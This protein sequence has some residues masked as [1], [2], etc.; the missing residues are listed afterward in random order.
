MSLRLRYVRWAVPWPA[1]ATCL[2]LAATGVLLTWWQEEAARFVVPLVALLVAA[3]AAYALDDTAAPVTRVTARG[4]RWAMAHRLACAALVG[5]AGVGLIAL[6]PGEL[7]GLE[8]WPVVISGLV[9]AATASA[10]WLVRRHHDAPGAAVASALV[11][12]GLLP[13]PATMLFRFD[14][15]YPEPLLAE[16]IRDGWLLLAAVAA[17][18]LGWAVLRPLPARLL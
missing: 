13:F 6:M 10:A 18:A 16:G 8:G 1:V 2:V 5:L 17:I 12:L 9:L 4:S 14:W 11:L 15:P 3:G 7:G